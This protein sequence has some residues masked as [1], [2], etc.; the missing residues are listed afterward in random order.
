MIKIVSCQLGLKICCSQ[1]P[2]LRETLTGIISYT[3]FVHLNSTAREAWKLIISL[4]G[5]SLHT[6]LKPPGK[7]SLRQY[8]RRLQRTRL[9]EKNGRD[10][11]QLAK[12]RLHKESGF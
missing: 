5:R 11:Q 6:Y 8:V 3:P 1:F 2:T 10:L 4:G 12:I 7:K 9:T